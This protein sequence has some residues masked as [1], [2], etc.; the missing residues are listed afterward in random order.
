MSKYL[1]IN[2]DF[3]NDVDSGIK[4]DVHPLKIHLRYTKICCVSKYFLKLS[5]DCLKW[6]SIVKV[7]IAPD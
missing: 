4:R 3:V 5:S 1:K 6:Y 7:P 2:D